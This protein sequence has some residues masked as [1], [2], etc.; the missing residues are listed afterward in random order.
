MQPKQRLQ[1]LLLN[2]S[3]LLEQLFPQLTCEECDTERINAAQWEPRSEGGEPS[4]HTALLAIKER[5]VKSSGRKGPAMDGP[6]C[7][8][9]WM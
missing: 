4:P 8:C 3:D 6:F 9:K 1:L 7:C 5:K 2:S